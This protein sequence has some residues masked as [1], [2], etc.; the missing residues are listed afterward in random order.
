MRRFA[1]ALVFGALGCTASSPQVPD[2]SSA[3]PEGSAAAENV[4]Q[5]GAEPVATAAPAAPPAPF[6]GQDCG[7]E[8]L[9]P[10]AG[11]D[12]VKRACLLDAWTAGR[13]ARLTI[14]LSTTEGDPMGYV[15]EVQGP[16]RLRVVRDT[17][18][19]RFGPRAVTTYACTG[20]EREVEGASKLGFAAKGCQG[21]DAETLTVP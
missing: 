6:A 14:A 3:T 13:P 20:L 10:A 19:D 21:G 9:R 15:L 11:R 18:H 1:F 12:E 8:Y 16:G 2:A 4:G 17:T 7:A 5:T